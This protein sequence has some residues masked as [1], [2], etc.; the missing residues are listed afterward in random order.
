MDPSQIHLTLHG[1]DELTLD[2]EKGQSVVNDDVYAADSV[3]GIET[4]QPSAVK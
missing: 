2:A 3:S 1:P 4:S